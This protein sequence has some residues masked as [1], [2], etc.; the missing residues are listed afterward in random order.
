VEIGL[1]GDANYVYLID[2]ARY[3]DATMQKLDVSK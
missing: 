2:V 1:A 3:L